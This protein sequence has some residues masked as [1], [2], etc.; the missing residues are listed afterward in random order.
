MLGYNLGSLVAGQT[1]SF[2][3]YKQLDTGV[4]EPGS[5]ALMLA[6]LGAVAAL[7]RR[8]NATGDWPFAV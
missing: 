4:P 5:W 7:R 6:G 1:T 8:R 3:C 2:T